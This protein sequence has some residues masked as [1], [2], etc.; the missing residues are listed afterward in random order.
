MGDGAARLTREKLGQAGELAARAG[1]DLWLTFVRETAGG[2]DP[3]L[4]LILEGGLT[5]QSAL[6]VTARGERIAVVGNFDADPLRA[7]G[8]W[9]EV[10]PYTQSLREPL[11]DALERL[12]PE[13]GRAPRI[14]VNVSVDDPKA[15]GLTHGMFLRLESLLQGTRFASSLESAEAILLPLRS[16]KTP[17]EL[18]RIREAIAA[19][20]ALFGEI[21]AFVR[22]GV[23]ELDIQQRIQRAVEERGL[24]YGWDR[25]GDPIVNCGPD[26]PVGHGLPSAEIRLAPGQILHLDLGVAYE[27]YSSDMQRCWYLPRAGEREAPAEVRRAIDAVNEAIRAGAERL[28][29]GVAGWEV[30]A[31]ARERIV[32][33]GY[34]EYQH[35]LGHQVGRLAHDGGALLGPRWER[36]GRMPELPV[37]RDQVF[38]LELGVSVVGCG[39]VGL[40]EMVLVTERGCRWLTERQL[41]M[42]LLPA[43]PPG[44][45]S[46]S[47]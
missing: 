5:W 7:S 45:L 19:T 25:T 23:S 22:A 15:D 12:L 10:I 31:A 32:A 47:G 35:A 38:T 2:G 11:L 14:A 6:M 16:R 4:P 13:R 27:G 29:P 36:Y 37:E 44:P 43:I 39:F 33:C 42:R 18:R 34:P 46:G 24:G 26:S 1:V 21:P 9:S 40:E 30:D 3:V 17:E 20:E 28:R 8:D 41:E